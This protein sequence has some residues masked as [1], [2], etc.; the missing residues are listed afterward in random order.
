MKV[1][2]QVISSSPSHTNNFRRCFFT[3]AFHK[4]MRGMLNNRSPWL[5]KTE[6]FKNLAESLSSSFIPKGF[7]L[8]Q[9]FMF[10]S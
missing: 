7:E 6:V 1:Q 8:L 4:L 5:C 3:K 9:D 2:F 10:Q